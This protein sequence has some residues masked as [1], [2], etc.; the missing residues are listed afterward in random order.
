MREITCKGLPEWC[1][2]LPVDR[3]ESLPVFRSVELFVRKKQKCEELKVS[4]MM[5]FPLSDTTNSS[6]H[7]DWRPLYIAQV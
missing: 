6:P 4:L 1:P 5:A 2:L 3:V 7:Q